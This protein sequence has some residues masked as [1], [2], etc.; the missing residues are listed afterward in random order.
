VNY[1]PTFSSAPNNVIWPKG[2]TV[3]E[4]DIGPG[5]KKMSLIVSVC[6]LNYFLNLPIICIFSF[7]ARVVQFFKL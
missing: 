7:Y 1:G 2:G 5:I 3:R 4:R 6:Y